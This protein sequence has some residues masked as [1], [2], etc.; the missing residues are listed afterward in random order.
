MDVNVTIKYKDSFDNEFTGI[1]ETLNIDADVIDSD[2]DEV[3]E[4][5]KRACMA[6]GFHPKSVEKIIYDEEVTK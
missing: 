3:L 4:H 5:F 2:L 1:S 6:C